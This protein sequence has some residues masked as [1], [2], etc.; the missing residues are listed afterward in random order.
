MLKEHPVAG[1]GVGSFHTLVHDF[2]KAAS[3]KDIVPDNA[4]N[5]YRHHLAELGLLGSLPWLAWCVVFAFTLF[6]PATGTADRFSIGVLRGALVAFGVISLLGMPGQS[7]PV[8]LT[9]WTLA[10]WFAGIKGVPSS[11]S[12]P[13]S[14]VGWSATLVVVILHAAVTFADARGDLRPRNRSMR[15]GW[16]YRTAWATSNSAP[17][18]SRNAGPRGTTGRWR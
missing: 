16:E 2:A 1:V 11:P 7:L 10:F 9:F 15:F 17:M 5:W 8:V 18:A 3:G 14:T 13:W 4:Q 12:T 6:S